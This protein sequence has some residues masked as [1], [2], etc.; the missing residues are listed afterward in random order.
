MFFPHA[1]AQIR[2][3]TVHH[4]PFTAFQ[5]ICF[6]GLFLHQSLLSKGH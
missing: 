3:F 4:L 1:A 6:F 2:G 5:R